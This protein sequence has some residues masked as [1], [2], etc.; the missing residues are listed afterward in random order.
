M[1]IQDRNSGD[2][3]SVRNHNS[4]ESFAMMPQQPFVCQVFHVFF[5]KFR[6]FGSTLSD[7]GPQKDRGFVIVRDHSGIGDRVDDL[8]SS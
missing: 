3:N 7:W 1:A 6:R 4:S 2:S 8:E 5:I